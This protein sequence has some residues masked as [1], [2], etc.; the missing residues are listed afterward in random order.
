[1]GRAPL[2]RAN[3]RSRP[4]QSAVRRPL[5]G[6]RGPRAGA[7]S[8]RP[9]SPGRCWIPFLIPARWFFGSVSGGVRRHD[10]YP[11]LR[12]GLRGQGGS[13]MRVVRLPGGGGAPTSR[14][15]GCHSA[16]FRYIPA[17]RLGA[18][19]RHNGGGPANG[20][21]HAAPWRARTTRRKGENM[22]V[23]VTG[24]RRRDGRSGFCTPA[25]SDVGA[26]TLRRSAG[27]LFSRLIV[28]GKPD[29]FRRDE[30]VRSRSAGLWKMAARTATPA[31]EA[32]G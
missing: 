28:R 25:P 20:A 5:R 32:C 14:E 2:W 21:K 29:P 15:I 24:G 3:G 19:G 8:W 10:G 23:S 31:G 1:M 30:A 27:R 4:D 13:A 16:K 17:P 12:R 22:R 9:A 18:R 6:I 26:S 11:P 7:R